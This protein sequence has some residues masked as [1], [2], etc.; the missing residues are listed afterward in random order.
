M[1][2]PDTSWMKG[3]LA[4]LSGSDAKSC[5]SA[6]RLQKVLTNA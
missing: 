6:S 2:I 5:D 4:D 1:T 3:T